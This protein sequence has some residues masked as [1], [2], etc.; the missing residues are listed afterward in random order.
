[1]NHG[2]V[3]L[4]EVFAAA[5]VRAAS[6][7]PETSGYLVLAI[8]DAS[9]RLP[10][11]LDE[12]A[13]MLTTEGNVT[14]SRRG[15]VVSPR[16]AGRALRDVLARLLAVSSGTMP[17][18]AGAG[19][20]REESERGVDAVIEEIEAALIPVNRAAARRAL[21]R[22]ARETLRAK[23][24]GKLKPRAAQAPKQVAPKI[25]ETAALPS[26]PATSAPAT[27]AP[28][29]ER[30]PIPPPEL[31]ATPAP[32]TPSIEAA[33]A[34]ESA[35]ADHDFAPLL[36][37]FG[38][39]DAPSPSAAVAPLPSMIVAPIEP[40]AR[41]LVEPLPRVV[42]TE[43]RPAAASIDARP[44]PAPEP[45]APAA[46]TSEPVI[47]ATIETASEPLIAA[48]IEPFV[49]APIAAPI[50]P[51]SAPVIAASIEP[52][53]AEPIA[54]PIEPASEPAIAEPIEP[55]IAEPIEPSISE[56][57]AIEPPMEAPAPMP[58][59]ALADSAFDVA[60]PTPTVLGMAIEIDDA[61][62]PIDVLPA[63][64]FDA[65]AAAPE[66]EAAPL[67]PCMPVT[68]IDER[69]SVEQSAISAS[70][71]ASP[72]L[73]TDAGDLDS[74]SLPA[75]SADETR[76]EAPLAA[77][78]EPVSSAIEEHTATPIDE[79]VASPIEEQAVEAIEEQAAAPIEEQALEAIE[80]Q[81]ATPLDE[82]D[83]HADR[84]A[85]RLADRRAR[86]PRRA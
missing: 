41:V 75:T 25:V 32:R 58:S 17:G 81:A 68:L 35:P 50:E 12:R 57:I 83:R 14:L 3:T 66:E 86:S 20:P 28:I 9:S 31:V 49:A 63:V 15:E 60:E 69:A 1:M 8:G 74:G 27:S 72:A 24:A 10:L 4:D 34:P 53:V 48:S 77:H 2:C 46:L 21:G 84:R 79:P 40:P 36:E 62:T 30:S 78:A 43:P 80:E 51:M 55:V 70:D 47:S 64:T 26:A 16:V 29:R 54:A 44:A 23:E 67:A 5:A 6:L 37:G 22:L 19:R 61:P 71:V 18:L 76:A 7:V 59:P 56:P 85:R 39:S 11:S 82:R 13:L 73:E 42:I 65:I 38:E 52:I 33:L 45:E